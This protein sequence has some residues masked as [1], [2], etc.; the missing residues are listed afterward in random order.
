MNVRT[1]NGESKPLVEI[2]DD[3]KSDDIEIMKPEKETVSFL[4][5]YFNSDVSRKIVANRYKDVT[6]VKMYFETKL[7]DIISK[8]FI[9]KEL[10]DVITSS[11]I[12]NRHIDKGSKILLVSDYDVD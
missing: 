5:R 4:N 11:E 1:P 8:E 6:N 10:P 12:I 7:H 2:L 3:L 9:E